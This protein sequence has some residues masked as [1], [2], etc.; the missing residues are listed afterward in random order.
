MNVIREI[1][2]MISDARRLM[3]G[4]RIDIGKIEE[5]RQ[6]DGRDWSVD[7]EM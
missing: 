5:D 1:I 2:L 4:L 3:C 6:G 7:C